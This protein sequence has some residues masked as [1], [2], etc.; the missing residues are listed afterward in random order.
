VL[1]SYKMNGVKLHKE[2]NDNSIPVYEMKDGQIGI[3][4]HWTLRENLNIVVQRYGQN[5]IS[6]GKTKIHT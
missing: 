3:T 2:Y 1:R 6:L 5:L 4:T